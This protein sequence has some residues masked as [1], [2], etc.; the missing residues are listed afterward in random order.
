MFHQV[1]VPEQQ[2]IY[3]KF[4]WKKDSNLSEEVLY[5]GMMAN[6]FGGERNTAV[7][8]LKGYSGY[9]AIV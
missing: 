3:Q 4:I 7:D 9:A 2:R 1:G 8:N 5:H 6:V